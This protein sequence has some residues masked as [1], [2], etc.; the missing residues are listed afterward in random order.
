MK[1]RFMDKFLNTI[2]YIAASLSAIVLIGI[3]IYI[4]SNGFKGLSVGLITGDYYDTVYELYSEEKTNKIFI[5]PNDV[6][7]YFSKT[8][9]IVL[10]DSQTKTGEKKVVITYID[11]DSV[12]YRLKDSQTKDYIK[13]KLGLSISKLELTDDTD[14]YIYALSKDGARSI[15]K[16]L[17]TANRIT[18]I[19]LYS[20]GGGIRGSLITTFYLIVLTL[21]IALPIGIGGAIYLHEY[22][23]DNKLTKAIRI[24]IDMTSGIPSIIFGLVGALVFIPFV[25]SITPSNGGSILSGALTL[26]IILLPVIIRTT[27]EALLTIPP[28][29][30]QASLALGA[31]RTQTVFKVILPNALSGILTA[32]LLSIGRIIGESAALIYAVGTT[33]KDSVSVTSR[34]TSLAVH[35]WSVM[36]GESPNY[37][38]ACSI[39][40][41]ILIIVL[42]L[43]IL[44]KIIGKKLNKFEVK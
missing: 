44:V 24:M 2:T 41:I 9:G 36:S 21:L 5:E 18:N 23:K 28:S 11:E 7:G 6:D 13:I 42:C 34:S 15:I 40:I 39:S 19:Q 1:T 10:K 32:A 29:Y 33:I 12:F 17:D 30:K 4:F 26:A 8:W 37:D 22:A 3:L 38:L 14:D 27:E 31:S 35:I 43:S 25:N 20:D 16:N